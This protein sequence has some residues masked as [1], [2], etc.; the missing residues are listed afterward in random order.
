MENKPINPHRARFYLLPTIRLGWWAAGLL[1]AF[2]AL[3]VTRFRLHLGGGGWQGGGG[4]FDNPWLRAQAVG[5]GVAAV[6]SGAIAAFAVGFHRER[7]LLVFLAL[8]VGL[9]VA[10]FSL[11]EIAGHD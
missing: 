3:F 4:F 11:G 7:S 5:A 9:F 8:I 2:A 1:V 10:A 6:L